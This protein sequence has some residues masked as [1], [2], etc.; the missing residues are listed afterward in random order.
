MQQGEEPTKKGFVNPPDTSSLDGQVGLSLFFV[1]KHPFLLSWQ[2]RGTRGCLTDLP[3]IRCLGAFN[4]VGAL[5]L[6]NVFRN[7]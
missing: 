6:L 5:F 7:P 2:G 4:K 1:T 3:R